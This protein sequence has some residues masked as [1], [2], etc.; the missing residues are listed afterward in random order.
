MSQ[1][2]EPYEDTAIY[3]RD[4]GPFQITRTRV[5]LLEGR[6]FSPETGKVVRSVVT[7]VAVSGNVT[8]DEAEAIREWHAGGP[9]PE[10]M[11][12]KKGDRKATI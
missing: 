2:S 3:E 12:G 11:Q 10:F 7:N 4:G 5:D 1:W 8:A 9:I 6:P